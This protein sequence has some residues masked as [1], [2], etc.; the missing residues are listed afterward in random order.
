MKPHFIFKWVLPL[1][2]AGSLMIWCAPAQDAPANH[3]YSPMIEEVLK[4]ES[5]GLSKE[6]IKTYIENSPVPYHLTAADLI[7]LKDRGITDDLMTA[8]IKRGA[9]SSSEAAKLK[10]ATPRE[11]GRQRDYGQIDPEGYDFFSYYYLYPRTLAFANQR[12]LSADQPFYDTPFYGYGYYR[13]FPFRP[14]PPSAFRHP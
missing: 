9:E 1:L 8:L 7:A 11:S 13:P 14:L 12:L 6:V 2:L 5:A 10:P 4:M 3:K